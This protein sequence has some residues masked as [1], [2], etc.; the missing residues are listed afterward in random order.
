[1]NYQGKK[2]S[3]GLTPVLSNFDK[4]ASSGSSD[5]LRFEKYR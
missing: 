2:I 1:M 3:V 4:P 5:A